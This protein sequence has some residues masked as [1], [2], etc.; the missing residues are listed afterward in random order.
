[1]CLQSLLTHIYI[2]IYQKSSSHYCGIVDYNSKNS[3]LCGK[4]VIVE[5]KVRLGI[6][7]A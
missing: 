7:S 1:M 4:R 6:N 5:F 3:H 2:Y